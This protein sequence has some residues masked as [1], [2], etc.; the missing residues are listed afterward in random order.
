MEVSGNSQSDGVPRIRRMWHILSSV[1]F[2][3]GIA[4]GYV[5]CALIVV[6]VNFLETFYAG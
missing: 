2:A 5:F 1:E 4:I 3:W 6:V